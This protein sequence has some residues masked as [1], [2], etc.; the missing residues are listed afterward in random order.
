MEWVRVS[1]M[2]ADMRVSRLWRAIGSGKT[3]YKLL[4]AG[5]DGGWYVTRS[6]GHR[7]SVVA[8]AAGDTLRAARELAELDNNERMV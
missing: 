6:H 2:G 7:G 5:P 8:V 3:F 4:P 1:T